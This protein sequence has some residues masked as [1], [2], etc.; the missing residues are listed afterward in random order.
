MSNDQR[1]HSKSYGWRRWGQDLVGI[2]DMAIKH[3]VDRRIDVDACSVVVLL[4]IE[5]P[6]DADGLFASVGDGGDAAS[7]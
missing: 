6:G 4:V 1:F 7:I 2:T 5:F 3:V